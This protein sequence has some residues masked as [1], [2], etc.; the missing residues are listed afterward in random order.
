[1]LGQQRARAPNSPKK[2]MSMLVQLPMALSMPLHGG[3]VAQLFNKGMI[4]CGSIATSLAFV[5]K[6]LQ[7]KC[8]RQLRRVVIPMA[9]VSY[10]IMAVEDVTHLMQMARKK[11]ERPRMSTVDVGERSVRYLAELAT[12]AVC[13]GEVSNGSDVN[14]ETLSGHSY[15]RCI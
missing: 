13:Y 6:A 1:M 12:V 9:L 15:Q 2:E 11:T 14:N 4:L 5:L 7:F 8:P 3:Q 10:M